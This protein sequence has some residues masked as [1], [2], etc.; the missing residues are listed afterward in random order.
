M[1][2]LIC[3]L[4]VIC[5]LVLIREWGQKSTLDRFLLADRKVGG[6]VGSMSIAASWIWAPAIFVSSQ[7]GYQWGL[8]GLVWFVIP[9]MLALF[10]F[11][12]LAN[13]VRK[14][15]PYGYSYVEYIG[16]GH[17][18]FVVIQLALQLIMQVVIFAIQLVAGAE[19][20]SK[21]TG[22]SYGW[23]VIGMTVTPLCY[24]LFSGLRTSVFT[25]AVQ[26]VV[27]AFAALGILFAFPVSLPSYD[28]RPFNPFDPLMLSEFGISSAL[29]LIV[30]IFADH[31][32]WQRAF[33][34]KD[35]MI[36][37]TYYTAALLHGLVTISLGLVGC[38]IYSSGFNTLRTDLVGIEFISTHY[39]ALFTPLFVTM[40]ICA[41]ISTLDSA[42][43]AFS[44][45][46]SME[47]CQNSPTLRQGRSWMITLAASA[48]AIAFL[49]PSLLTL[50][51]LASTIRLS[52]FIPTVASIIG[53]QSP[54]IRFSL[55]IG[56]ALL[57]GGTVFAL[58]IYTGDS[59]IR[60]TG[61][62]LSFVVSTLA[63][64]SK[65][66]L[67]IRLHSRS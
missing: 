31:Q 32:Q 30:A 15:L 59:S 48:N 34:I 67:D 35:A 8:S 1:S 40:A 7:I 55:A 22:A 44:S 12:P 36:T 49:R 13:K 3:Y 38:L 6:F 18:S 11:A 53:K 5:A 27:I 16:R 42:L 14:T 43:C 23:M 26:Y 2:Y 58:G 51:F 20:L 54:T 64:T 39:N 66:S 56:L 29:G 45:L 19:L 61:M 9:N 47:L 24:T 10:I 33:S 4:I 17:R 25:D 37:R 65:S 21:L 57:I 50:W 60:T 41:L 52:S 63:L 62:V 46:A 28:T